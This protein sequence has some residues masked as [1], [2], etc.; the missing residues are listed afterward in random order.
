MSTYP[1]VVNAALGI[2]FKV[3]GSTRAEKFR[4]IRSFATSK[5]RIT[6]I[7]KDFYVFGRKLM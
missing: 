3:D 6:R 2:W 1:E 7:M 4:K 5:R